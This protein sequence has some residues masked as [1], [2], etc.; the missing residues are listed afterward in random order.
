VVW[1][2]DAAEV[3]LA[4]E[5]LF[6]AWKRDDLGLRTLC[7]LHA[8]VCPDDAAR[9]GRLRDKNVVVR[10]RGDVRYCPPRVEVAEAQTAASLV[11]LGHT[12]A[13]D[14]HTAFP[15]EIAAEFFVRLTSAHPFHDGNGRVAREV[16]T[17]ILSTCGYGAVRSGDLRSYCFARVGDYYDALARFDMGGDLTL[18]R[19]LFADAVSACLHSRRPE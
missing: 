5:L 8:V 7:N 11:W 17:W 14:A 15:V 6:D 18:W 9:P 4:H 1:A 10:L 19:Q 2:A 16:A 12:L 13:S 3:G